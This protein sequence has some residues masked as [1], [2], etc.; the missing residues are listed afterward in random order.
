V[1]RTS[2]E[3]MLEMADADTALHWHLTCYHF[4]PIIGGEAFAKLAIDAANAGEWDKVIDDGS[5]RGRVADVVESWHLDFFLH[6]ED[7]AVAS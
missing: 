3:G 5:R 1:G 4:P 7:E 2:L 6:D